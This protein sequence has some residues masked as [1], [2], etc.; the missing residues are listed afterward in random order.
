MDGHPFGG[1]MR[2]TWT[3][4]CVVTRDYGPRIPSAHRVRTPQGPEAEDQCPCPGPSRP[5]HPT[6]RSG[7]PYKVRPPWDT[8]VYVEG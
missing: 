8:Y 4:T 6:L 3:P 7:R 2:V 1:G 5:T